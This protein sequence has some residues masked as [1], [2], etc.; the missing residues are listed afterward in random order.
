MIN[1]NA[2]RTGAAGVMARA[3]G[4]LGA[5]TLLLTSTGWGALAG[6]TGFG[7]VNLNAYQGMAAAV[8]GPA[9]K[10]VNNAQPGGNLQ[11]PLQAA[12]PPPNGGQVPIDRPGIY[13]AISGFLNPLP[14][15]NPD[16]PSPNNFG[17]EQ[18]TSVRPIR[19][20][21]T[22]FLPGNNGPSFFDNPVQYGTDRVRNGVVL[23]Q[24]DKGVDKIN[25]PNKVYQ[26]PPQEMPPI[27]NPPTNFMPGGSLY[28]TAPRTPSD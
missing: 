10:G 5:A 27:S 4:T 11:G 17:I 6:D 15:L 28:P 23:N 12:P 20:P 26:S 14:A 3:L 13:N 9:P 19:N 18:P 16:E 24:I 22:N 1:Q 7:A 25:P 2:R 8:P 21:P